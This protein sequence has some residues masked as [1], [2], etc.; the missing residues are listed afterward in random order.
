MGTPV[1]VSIWSV[2]K[3]PWLLPVQ[4]EIILTLHVFVHEALSVQVGSLSC[5]NDWG[6]PTYSLYMGDSRLSSTNTVLVLVVHGAN[7]SLVCNYQPGEP[8]SQQTDKYFSDL[9]SSLSFSIS[10]NF[11]DHCFQGRGGGV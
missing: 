5:I 1:L 8:Q 6:Q 9:S 11:D 10:S 4:V 7:K 2:I 3:V